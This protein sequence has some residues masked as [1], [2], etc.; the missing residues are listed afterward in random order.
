[1]ILNYTE[2][3]NAKK[4]HEEL[5]PLL[6]KYEKSIKNDILNDNRNQLN[7]FK[8]IYYSNYDS[9][10]NLIRLLDET[11]NNSHFL[12]NIG[13]K[14]ISFDEE[15]FRKEKIF[16]G[17]RRY[18]TQ[19]ES[20]K[21][22]KEYQY[23]TKSEVKRERD[24]TVS[25]PFSTFFYGLGFFG[26]AVVITVFIVPLILVGYGL[27]NHIRNTVQFFSENNQYINMYVGN[28]IFTMILIIFGIKFGKKNFHKLRYKVFEG[29]KYL[30]AYLAYASWTFLIA[31]IFRMFVLL[32]TPDTTLLYDNV[33]SSLITFIAIVGITL[34]FYAVPAYLIL[35]T[36]C[37]I[38]AFIYRKSID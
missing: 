31:G 20:E 11:N 34:V 2:I 33:F 8:K 18:D 27:I 37:I 22:T 16:D 24:T 7:D 4:L 6:E 21:F 38:R 30:Y 28:I 32:T 13:V 12:Q 17:G 5:D 10:E 14:S 3:H 23:K 19:K 25:N 36:I 1:M 35:G 9:Y 15:D 26:S 29:G